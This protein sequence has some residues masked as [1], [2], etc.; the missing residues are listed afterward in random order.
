MPVMGQ[1]DAQ[2]VRPSG[3]RLHLQKGQAVVRGPPLIMQKRLTSPCGLWFDHFDA[4]L[5]AIPEQPIFQRPGL[6]LHFALDNRP[7][8]L[9]DASLAKLLRETC[10]RLAGARAGAGDRRSQHRA[11]AGLR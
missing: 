9:L 5:F 10:G 1:L 11:R 6:R 4:P 8:S 2:L 7:V 3:L